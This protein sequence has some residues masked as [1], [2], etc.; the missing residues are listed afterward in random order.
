M[1][2]V[3]E[4]EDRVGVAINPI[5]EVAHEDNH[6]VHDWPCRFHV[7]RNNVLALGLGLGRGAELSK[8]FLKVLVTHS[9]LVLP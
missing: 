2:L 8:C 9:H 7:R 3:H 1:V 6:V 5:V 4:L